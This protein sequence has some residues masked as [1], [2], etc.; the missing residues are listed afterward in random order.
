MSAVRLSD[1]PATQTTGFG[2]WQALNEP[3]GVSGLGVNAVVLDPGEEAETGHDEGETGQQ[4]VYVVVSGRA[5]FRVGDEEVDAP[6]GTVVAA[7]DPATHRSFSAVEPG[8]RVVCFGAPADGGAGQ[9]YGA[10]I[11]EAAR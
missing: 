3:L 11:A 9:S 4:E 2:R 5:S 6:A 8:T 7:P 1:H 10:W